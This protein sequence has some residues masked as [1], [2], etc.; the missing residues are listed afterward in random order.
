M[1]CRLSH[2]KDEVAK[3][4]AAPSVE[5]ENGL[6]VLSDQTFEAGVAQ[7]YTLVKFYAPYAACLP[8]C[9]FSLL[10]GGADTASALLVCYPSG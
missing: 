8:F 6:K 5:I 10:A 9:S 7:G 2:R 1:H 3:Q 4:D